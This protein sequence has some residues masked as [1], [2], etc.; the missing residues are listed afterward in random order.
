MSSL[1]RIL[2]D[3]AIV[4]SGQ[5]VTWLATFLFV[6]AQAR[7]LGPASFGELSLALSYA[8][9]F[10]VVVD[11]GV[12]TYLTRAVAQREN[13]ERAVLWTAVTTRAALWLIAMPLAWLATM[14]LGYEAELQATTLILVGSL[15]FVGSSGALTAFYQGKERFLL[16][17]LANIVQRVAAAI[18][19]ILVLQ[20]GLGVISVAVV[21]AISAAF[22]LI[23]L[24]A[25]LRGT[26]LLRIRVE[27]RANWR[28]VRSVLPIAIYWVAGTLYFNVDMVLITMSSRSL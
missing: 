15:L 28:L 22:A 5:V 27:P 4:S 17:T 12:S 9:F 25:G 8:T 16:P 11:F 24:A 19:G 18:V 13:A 26:G 10:A 3:V 6:L 14:V 2:R 21:Y 20:A 1:R 23:L 7:S